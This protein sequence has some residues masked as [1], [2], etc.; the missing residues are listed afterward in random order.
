MPSDERT[1]LAL[2]A[3]AHPIAVFRAAI[4]TV[5]ERARGSLAA[6]GGAE[7]ARVELGQFAAGRID[8]A[9]FAKLF[10]RGG[11]LDAAS[12]RAIRRALDVLRE[13]GEADDDIFVANVPAGGKMPRVIANKLARLGRAFGA[14]RI[15]ELARAGAYRASEHDAWLEEFP[16]DDWNRTERRLAPPVIVSVDGADLRVGALAEFADGAEKIV[17][18]VRRACAPAPLERLITPGTFVLQTADAAE[19]ARAAAVDGPAIAA[20]VPKDAAAFVHDPSAGDAPWQRL[21]VRYVPEKAPAHALGALSAWE[22]GEELKQLLAMA[23]RPPDSALAGNG[24]AAADPAERLA[25]WL[26][27]RANLGTAS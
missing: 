6:G 7:R 1:P 24:A 2:E 16:F 9:R 11:D 27:D 10:H 13:I 26:L 20:L 18:L 15:V 4:V 12:E 8:A 19:L 14:A 25:A 5:T 22:Q 21:T 23:Q 3:L 17:I